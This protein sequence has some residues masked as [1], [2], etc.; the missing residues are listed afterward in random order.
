VYD[1]A[2]AHGEDH[3]RILARGKHRTGAVLGHQHK[4]LPERLD[5]EPLVAQQFECLVKIRETGFAFH[6]EV[7]VCEAGLP[8]PFAKMENTSAT[9]QSRISARGA[10]IGAGS[11]Q[12]MTTLR[13]PDAV[14]AAM[15]AHAEAAYP[16][17]CCG[18]ML[19]LCV[20]QDW[21]VV[22]AIAV[23][24]AAGGE[25]RRTHYEIDPHDLVSI[26]LEARQRQLEIAG[27]YHSHP[28]C[29]AKWS[30]TDLAGAHWIGASYAIIEVRDGRA[31]AI[32]SFRLAGTTEE[33]KRFEPETVAVVN[34]PPASID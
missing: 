11:E 8:G 23:E 10:A 33:H 12:P 5:L 7:P 1:R 25:A 29:P 30:S 27:F 31:T 22:S 9:F 28:D 21:Q 3:W 34:A 19:G 16:Y 14:A 26:V 6:R 18:V 20:G 4:T 17:E 15:R 24:N 2:W 13:L 32:L